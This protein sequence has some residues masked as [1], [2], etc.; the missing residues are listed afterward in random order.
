MQGAIPAGPVVPHHSA[1]D[2]LTIASR[3]SFLAQEETLDLRS[4]LTCRRC[5]RAAASQSPF[6]AAAIRSSHFIRPA[7]PKM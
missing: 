5:A 3:M 1:L 7:G 6:L 4:S 2:T